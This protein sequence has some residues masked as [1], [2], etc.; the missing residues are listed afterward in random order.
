VE[1]AAQIQLPP[2]PPPEPE[3]APVQEILPAS[4][5]KRLQESAQARRREIRKALDQAQ[6]RR[7]NAT[8]QNLVSR[9]QSFLQLS[10]EAEGKADMRQADAL[11]E[12]AQVL[13]RELQNG[14]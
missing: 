3:R 11:A 12:R 13:A 9:I 1:P 14:R 10:E 8:Q 4:E 7:L 5:Q 6:S 2:T